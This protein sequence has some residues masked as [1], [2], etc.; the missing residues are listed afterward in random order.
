MDQGQRVQVRDHTGARHELPVYDARK[1]LSE[2]VALRE[3]GTPKKPTKE[4]TTVP[5]VDWN[6]MT[7]GRERG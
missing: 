3:L 7:R 4:I 6:G 2:A 5:S 1:A